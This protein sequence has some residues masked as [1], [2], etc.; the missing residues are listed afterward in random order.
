VYPKAKR[1]AELAGI[2]AIDTP[3]PLCADNRLYTLGGQQVQANMTA[4]PKGI[5]IKNGRKFIIR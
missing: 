1:D 5:Y 4:L 3:Q 2:V